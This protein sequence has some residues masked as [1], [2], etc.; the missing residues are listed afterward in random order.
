MLLIKLSVNAG[1]GEFKLQDVNLDGL[2]GFNELSHETG[3][4][5]KFHNSRSLM[6]VLESP[7]EV[8][9]AIEAERSRQTLQTARL[10]RENVSDMLDAKLDARFGPLIEALEANG[11]SVREMFKA[12]VLNRQST[13]EAEIVGPPAPAPAQLAHH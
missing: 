2:L 3:T 5:I 8:R 9:A 11:L 12:S 6:W 10:I 4:M 7:D 13:A 1:S